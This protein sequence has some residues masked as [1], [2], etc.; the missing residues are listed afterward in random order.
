MSDLKNVMRAGLLA[1]FGLGLAMTPAFAATTI[2]V[3]LWDK[4][5]DTDMTQ[6]MGMAMPDAD[7]KDT[8]PMGIKLSAD[9]APAG[10]VT[11]DVTNVSADTVHE[12]IVAP[13]ADVN[14]P[15]P[16]DA[17]MERV[18]EEAAGHLGEVSELD[19]GASG[20]LTITLKP[21]KYI[22]YCN[23]P[24]HYQSGMWT[25]FTAN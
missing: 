18:D 19:P 17:S 21:G 10:E 14:T 4:G 11:F 9:R 22:L 12:M 23:I 3:E 20:K 25:L 7:K 8:A 6:N 13:V 1:V 5:A 24:G 16:Y 15:L 2:K